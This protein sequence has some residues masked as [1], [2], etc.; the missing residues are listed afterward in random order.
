[1]FNSPQDMQLLQTRQKFLQLIQEERRR[2]Q[3][4]VEA[5]MN[6]FQKECEESARKEVEL[7]M[8]FFRE[9]EL[10]LMQ[11]DENTKHRREAERLRAQFEADYASRVQR[12]RDQELEAERKWKSKMQ[13]LEQQQYEH[14]QE[15]QRELD[16]ARER[17][18]ESQ[19]LSEIESRGVK[20]EQ[21]R[22][23]DAALHLEA[24][25][26]DIERLERDNKHK[27]E[28][29][30][31]IAKVQ[32]R[33]ALRTQ[34]EAVANERQHLTVE[35]RKL[36]QDRESIAKQM[37]VFNDVQ[38]KLDDAR[39]E[40]M[41]YAR[42]LQNLK[43]RWPVDEDVTA[44]KLLTT[45]NAKNM[46]A[47][48]ARNAELEGTMKAVQG[49]I[50]TLRATVLHEREVHEAALAERHDQERLLLRQIDELQQIVSNTNTDAKQCR[51]EAGERKRNPI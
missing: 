49:E 6:S 39:E 14:R 40:A 36:T 35:L 11:A 15:L 27:L 19:R 45:G 22:L 29:G 4:S 16:E 34:L 43:D 50:T 1:M 31:E 44:Q 12:L 47:L 13:V 2:P 41:N 46:L 25:Q 28:E 8:Q 51:M 23:K 38:R 10:S 37:E 26:R 5:V 3:R 9:R 30:A 33:E 21:V 24:K 32:A 48:T 17:V 20:L 42:Q 18:R 7:Q